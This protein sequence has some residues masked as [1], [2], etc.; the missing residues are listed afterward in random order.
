MLFR[1]SPTL[2]LMAAD[3]PVVPVIN[4]HLVASRLPCATLET[5]TGGHL[6]VLTRPAE[7]ARRIEAFVAAHPLP[8]EAS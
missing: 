6:F 4:G 8:L 7:T 2:V 5:V 3:D 1:S